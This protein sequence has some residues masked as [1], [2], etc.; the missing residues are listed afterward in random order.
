MPKLIVTDRTGNE[1]TTDTQEGLMVMEAIRDGGL[2]ELRPP[3]GGFCSCAKRHA[4]VGE[5]WT[6]CTGVAGGDRH[7]FLDSL[8]CRDPSARRSSHI[9]P[10]SA[11]HA[12]IA[13]ED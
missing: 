11:P 8:E 5:A 4:F 6:V 10:G 12:A 3:R 13:L 2:D 1:T 7:D 9:R